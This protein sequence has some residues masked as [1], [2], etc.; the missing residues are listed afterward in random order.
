MLRSLAPNPWK[1]LKK[2]VKAWEKFDW[3]LFLLI[4]GLT[5]FAGVMIQSIQLGQEGRS[6]WLLHFIF[7][8]VG[9]FLVLIMARFRY[10]FL[11]QWHW[12]I[13][14]IANILLIGVFFLGVTVNGAQN[15]LSLGGLTIQ[16]SEFA[17]LALIISLSAILHEHPASNLGSVFR[18]FGV[19][20]IP[21]ILVLLQPDLGTSLAFGAITLGMLYW[22]NANPGWLILIVSPLVS[23]I[24][25]TLFFPAW[26][27]WTVLM[28]I[29]AWLTLPLRFFTTILTVAMNLVAGELGSLL[30]GVLKPY[31]KDRL[32]LFLNPE[33]DPLGGG[34]HLIQSRIAIGSG[35]IWGK[36][37]HH[38]TQTQL[39]FVPEQHTDFIFSAVG[40]EYGFIG[41]ILVLLVFWLI[42]FRLIYIASTAKE[43]FGSLICVGILSMVIFQVIVNIGMTIGVAPITGIPLPWMSYGGS[44]LLTNFLALGIVESIA[45][46]RQKKRL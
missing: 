30:W 18:A 2:I 41:A 12:V 21:W 16:P 46:Y 19:T 8:G 34:Y 7:A 25:F 43:N 26:V 20:I 29:I 42:C 24:L 11:L 15:W 28:G 22:A 33:K 40:E 14:A 10:E 39:N 17:K 9:T 27:I 36:G 38:G 45:S 44:S 13:Y 32:T 4:V 6:E 35:E 23:I 37:L 5:N 31:Q 3:F 1:S